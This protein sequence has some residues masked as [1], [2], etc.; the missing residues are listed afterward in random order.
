MF[1]QDAKL[2]K[3]K[4]DT[5]KELHYL[6]KNKDKV[7]KCKLMAIKYRHYAIFISLNVLVSLQIVIS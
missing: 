3:K 5:I 4:E 1:L 7:T 2:N 6:F